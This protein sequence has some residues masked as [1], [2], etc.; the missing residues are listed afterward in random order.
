MKSPVLV[1]VPLGVVTEIRPEPAVGAVVS[2][3]VAAAE[4]IVE[5]T[6]LKAVCY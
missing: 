6:M 4:V 3:L 2:M 1:A 5:L